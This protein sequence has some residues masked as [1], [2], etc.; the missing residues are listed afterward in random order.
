MIEAQKR[1]IYTTEIFKRM[2]WSPGWMEALV[3]R[4]PWS[5][6]CKE[7]THVREVLRSNSHWFVIKIELLVWKDRKW[8]NKRLGLAHLKECL[9]NDWKVLPC[10]VTEVMTSLPLNGEAGGEAEPPLP[11]RRFRDP[12]LNMALMSSQANTMIWRRKS[13]RLWN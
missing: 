7:T 9:K 8:I 13:Q 5:N 4:E 6:G 2:A 3:G 10:G 11:M 1:K 12:P